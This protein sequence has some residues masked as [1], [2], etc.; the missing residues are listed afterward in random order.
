[1]YFSVL[2]PS[3]LRVVAEGLDNYR[4]RVVICAADEFVV[5]LEAFF[6]HELYFPDRIQ[7]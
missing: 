5:A 2:Y 7:N 1:M 6:F 3:L 4:Y